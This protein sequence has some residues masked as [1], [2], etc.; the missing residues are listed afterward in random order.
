M[1]M[2]FVKVAIEKTTYSF[3][4]E[5]TYKIPGQFSGLIAPGMRVMVPF[6]AGNTHR[7]A[8]ALELID[9]Y[10]GNTK[11]VTSILDEDPVINHEML[12]LLPFMKARY[13]CTFFEAI[14]TIL[15]FGIGFEIKNSYLLSEDFKNFDEQAYTQVQWQ[16]IMLLHSSMRA[17]AFETIS[18]KLGIDEKSPDLLSLLADSTVKKVNTA[19]SK[20]RDATSRMVRPVSDFNGKLT[21]KQQN[22]YNILCDVGTV[23]EKELCYF[24]GASSAVVKA[25][26]QKSAAEIFE[27][28]VYRR[29]KIHGNENTSV[30]PELSDEQSKIFE[31]LKKDYNCMEAKTAL[32]YGVTGSG[33]TSVF[34]KLIEYTINDGKTAILMV[35]EISL[36]AQT[37]SQFSGVFGDKIAIFHSALSLGERLD[38]WKRVK[39]GEARIVIGT[40]SAVFAPVENLGLIVMDEEQEHTYKSESSPRYDAREV[41]RFRCKE[42]GALCLFSSAT[43]SIEIFHMSRK[44]AVSLYE[45]PKR[46]GSAILPTVVLADMNNE[47]F[48]GAGDIIGETLSTALKENFENKKQSIILLNRRG[49]HTFAACNDCKEVI[50]C[51]HCSISLTY[52]SANGRLMCHYCGYSIKYEPRCP[53]CGGDRI[54]FRGMGTQRAEEELSEIL[55]DARIMRIDTDSVSK[56]FSLEQKLD[57]FADGDYDIMVGTQ[58]VAKG[59]DFENVTLV[60]VLSADQALYSDDYRANERTFDLLT[61][62]IGRA[63]RGKYPG[64]AVIQTYVPENPYLELSANQ[65]YIGFFNREIEFRKALLYPPFADILMFGFVGTSDRLVKKAAEAFM[66]NMSKTAQSEHPELPLRILR[67]SPAAVAKVSNKYRY[68]FIVKCRN[69]RSLREMVS[70]LILWFQNNSDYKAVTVYADNNPYSIM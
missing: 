29:P 13:Y 69:S 6:G 52:H 16:I 53:T 18:A 5:F 10:D 22:V 39:K 36:T 48:L 59:L 41:A 26:V 54:S 45:L 28:E 20:I 33:K 4:K 44:G 17:V 9:S 43:P 57:A 32:L 58:M 35:P 24:T 1:R 63:G 11:A 15:P 68:K 2:S 27:Y 49:Y 61:Q 8:M 51:P 25:L 3:D 64:T 38:E 30:M 21:A 37:I 65:D 34:L 67:P 47:S 42:H 60:G 62:V 19:S 7:V 55:P 46:F 14:K 12:K 66:E 40:R 70:R 50:S 23:S 56:R 31:S